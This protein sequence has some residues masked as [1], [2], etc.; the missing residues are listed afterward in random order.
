MLVLLIN[1]DRS[2]DRL[3]YMD[4]LLGEMGIRYTRVPAVDGRA[5]SEAQKK[6]IVYG[7]RSVKKCCFPKK[8]TDAE[9]GCFLSHRKCWQILADSDEYWA[10]IL[11]DDLIFNS[12]AAQYLASDE[13]IPESDY[14]LIQLS[15]QRTEKTHSVSA[16]RG[17][18]GFGDLL[19]TPLKP[20]AMGAQAYT[21]S[22]AAA[23]KALAHSKKLACVADSFLFGMLSPFYPHRRFGKLFPPIA[24][25]ANDEL[26]STIGYHNEEERPKIPVSMRLHPVRLWR[27]INVSCA[28]RL[29]R[30][31]V[32]FRFSKD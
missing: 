7:P 9:I 27:R 32:T 23:R 29:A 25:G 10:T 15:L 13:W 18:T 22:R 31:R 4:K 20:I 21:I 16:R 8:L 19:Y 2:T 26:E 17:K 1:L 14:D 12:R 5:L 6:E 11:E 24:T 28:R 30:E 3:A